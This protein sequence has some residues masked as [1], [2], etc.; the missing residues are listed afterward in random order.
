MFYG[1][2]VVTLN[3]LQDLAGLIRKQRKS[4]GIHIVTL[5]ALAN[6]SPKFISQLENGK[7]TIEVD[8]LLKVSHC[9]G[10]R[11][12]LLDDRS[13]LAKKLRE[14]RK[15]LNIEQAIAASLCGVSPR[16]LSSIENAKEKKRLNKLFAVLKGFGFELEAEVRGN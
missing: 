15:A 7:E 6:V 12:P 14:K 9:L 5:A 2:T 16:F 8:A 13:L 11:L 3:T 1:E 10:I 4:L